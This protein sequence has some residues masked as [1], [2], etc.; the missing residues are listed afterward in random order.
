MVSLKDFVEAHRRYQDATPFT[1]IIG[2]GFLYTQNPV[3][4]SIRDVATSLGMKYVLG[5]QFDYVTCAH[6]ALPKILETATASYIPNSPA[7]IK[8]EEAC[9]GMFPL[10][11]IPQIRPLFLLHESA[12]FIAYRAFEQGSMSLKSDTGQ[13]DYVFATLLGESFAT[14][15]ESVSIHFAVDDLHRE[16]HRLNTNNYIK[17]KQDYPRLV[18][19]GIDC[20]GFE[21][22]LK[23]VAIGFLFWNFGFDQLTAKGLTTVLKLCGV[24]KEPGPEQ[25][26]ALLELVN[27]S[28]AIPNEFRV[29]VADFYF[30]YVGIHRNIHELLRFNFL[31][32]LAKEPEWLTRLDALS[33][34]ALHGTR[35]PVALERFGAPSARSREAA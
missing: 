18:S 13:R 3:Y 34:M 15:C 19:R 24:R 12:H 5:D 20:L 16:F 33:T 7:F 22:M 30:K 28:F 26:K 21:A 17:D 25:R 31:E 32:K 10:A 8:I 6:A 29:Q 9:P 35:A 14:T 11:H 23:L 1:G 2:D 27:A 4:R